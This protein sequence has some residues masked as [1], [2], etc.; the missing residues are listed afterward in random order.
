MNVCPYLFF[1]CLCLVTGSPQQREQQQ[2]RPRQQRPPG[3]PPRFFSYEVIRTF[4]HPDIK[5]DGPVDP[6]SDAAQGYVNPFTQ[7]LF[8]EDLTFSAGNR[9]NSTDASCPLQSVSDK[10]SLSSDDSEDESDEEEETGTFEGTYIE[11]TG[12]FGHSVLR[13]VSLQTG[14]ILRTVPLPAEIFGEGS[15]RLNIP[16]EGAGSQTNSSVPV[17]TEA[18]ELEEA[19]GNGGVQKEGNATSIEEA[20]EVPQQAGNTTSGVPGTNGT[21]TPTTE[22]VIIMLSWQEGRAFVFSADDLELQSDLPYPLEGWGAACPPEGG[23]FYATTG[24]NSVYT[25]RLERREGNG[26]ETEGPWV[27]RMNVEA[28]REVQCLG[29][30][31]RGLNELEL[32][33]DELWSHVFG[34]DVLIAF[35]KNTLDCTK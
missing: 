24:G 21:G 22:S 6:G 11:S 1:V 10:E 7:G 31:I 15:C 19:A 27:I 20:A 8:L 32:V 4:P 2:R 30:P 29:I 17:T 13:R 35:D 14:E 18:G 33:G 25:H 3:P 16:V 34:A 26:T 9:C 28:P 12:G 5:S 23:T